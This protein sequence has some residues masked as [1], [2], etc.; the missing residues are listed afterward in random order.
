LPDGGFAL[1]RGESVEG[2]NAADLA[3]QVAGLH[4][5]AGVQARLAGADMKRGECSQLEARL[6]PLSI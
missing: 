3:G 5:D 2:S 6:R 4:A 1:Q